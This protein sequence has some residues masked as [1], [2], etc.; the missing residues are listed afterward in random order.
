MTE[1]ACQRTGAS[2]LGG[3]PDRPLVTLTNLHVTLGSVAILR[4]LNAEISRGKITALIGLNGA[5]KTTLLRALL[6]EVPVTGT[7]QFHC[8]HDHRQRYPTHIGYVPQRLQFDPNLPVTV[9]E[10][11]GLALRR[12]PIF[13]GLGAKLRRQISTLLRDVQAEH[14]AASPVGSLSGGELQR[15]LLA[16]AM[17]PPPELLLLDEPAAGI[18]FQHQGEFYRLIARLNEQTGVTVVLV[19]HDLSVVS[20]VAHHVLCLNDG[21]I[22]CA[23]APAQVLTGEMVQRIFGADKGVFS[24]RH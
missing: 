6:N 22:Q 24:H 21:R 10:L 4:G 2:S 3:G 1:A 11:L 18:D 19:S 15:V 7:I 13:L 20:Q 12:R 8:G 9:S 5:G 23:G 16:L 14:L 17:Y